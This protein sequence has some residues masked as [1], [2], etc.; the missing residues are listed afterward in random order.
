MEP[1]EVGEA[2]LVGDDGELDF[3][4]GANLRTVLIR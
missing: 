2:E 1:I 3:L 4:L